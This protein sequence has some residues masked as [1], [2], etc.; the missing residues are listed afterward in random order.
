MDYAI[1]KR[2]DDGELD[3]ITQPLNFVQPISLDVKGKNSQIWLAN[4][5]DTQPWR[6]TTLF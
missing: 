3:E 4:K 2:Y 5:M 1:Q 6:V